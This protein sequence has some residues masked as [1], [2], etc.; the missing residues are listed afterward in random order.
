MQND[1]AGSHANVVKRLRS[2]CFTA[3]LLVTTTL[4]TSSRAK[5]FGD[6]EDLK[7]LVGFIE[8]FVTG[9]E[10]TLGFFWTVG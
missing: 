9:G 6:R 10:T 1:V 5:R 4:Q 7:D 8:T 3:P 2:I